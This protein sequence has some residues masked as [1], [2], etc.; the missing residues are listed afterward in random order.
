[1]STESQIPVDGHADQQS[2]I[3]SVGKKRYRTE[4]S[5]QAGVMRP[6]EPS[7][8]QPLDGGRAP[9]GGNG[10]SQGSGGN[11]GSKGGGGQGGGQGGGSKG[12]GGS[13]QGGSSGSNG[14]NVKKHL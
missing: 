2:S 9:R 10:G 13:K 11:G 8:G 6:K 5:P 1:M 12:G 7:Q 14:G 3:L 4:G